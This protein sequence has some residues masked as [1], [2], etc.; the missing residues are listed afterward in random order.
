MA[1]TFI[2]P[3]RVPPS[4]PLSEFEW[5]ARDDVGSEAGGGG[6]GSCSWLRCRINFMKVLNL[7]APSALDQENADISSFVTDIN[8]NGADAE[9]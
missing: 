7:A 6:G 4:H 8:E 9:I 3:G 5:H 1:G 2:I